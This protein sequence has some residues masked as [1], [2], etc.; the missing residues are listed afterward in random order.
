MNELN[1]QQYQQPQQQFQQPQQQYQQPQQQYQQPQYQQSVYA[2]P[3]GMPKKNRTG[4]IIG[5]CAGGAAVIAVIVLLVVMLG[6]NQL[7]GTWKSNGETIVFTNDKITQ[8]GV[9]MNYRLDGNSIIISAGD[10]AYG[11][12][13]YIGD[14]LGSALNDITFTMTY[15]LV[16][17]KLTLS[18]FGS[19]VIYTRQ[20]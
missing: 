6:G 4:L 11:V 5:L 15:E 14:Y 16:G 13:D 12:S 10:V 7:V 17:D 9:S 1:E 19:E 2:Q 3:Y 18:S 20:K 8:S